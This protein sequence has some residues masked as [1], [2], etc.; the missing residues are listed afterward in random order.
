MSQMST[1]MAVTD[2]VA[3][4]QVQ[5]VTCSKQDQEVLYGLYYVLYFIF[6]NAITI[7]LP[8]R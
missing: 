1:L 3:V 6:Y 2:S 4:I 7:F 5:D 8:S